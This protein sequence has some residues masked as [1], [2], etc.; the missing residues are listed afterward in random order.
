MNTGNSVDEM[1]M[2]NCDAKHCS[3]SSS[4]AKK[5]TWEASHTSLNSK[6]VKGSHMIACQSDSGCVSRS[7][8]STDCCMDVSPVTASRDKD[9]PDF[10]PTLGGPLSMDN[11]QKSNC[12]KIML[13]NIVDDAKK[14]NL[15]KVI[16]FL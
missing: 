1:R 12:Y 15:T 13:M 8:K 6:K 3:C 14:L 11:A 2:K 9:L 7:N 4:G 5:R 10:T 16:W